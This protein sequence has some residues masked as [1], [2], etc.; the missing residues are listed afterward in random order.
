M[1]DMNK[2]MENLN[3]ATLACDADLK[4]LYANDKCK[5]LF[6]ASL[7]VEGFVGKSMVDCHKPETIEKLK[8]LFEEYKQK[9]RKVYHYTRETPDGILTLVNVPFYDGDTFG[10]VVEF[11][12]ESALG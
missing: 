5:K 3:T 8:D 4:V 2:I 7:K 11:I 10:G 1:T 12:F 6:K 9:T